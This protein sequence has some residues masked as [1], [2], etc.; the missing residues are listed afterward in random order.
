VL[1]NLFYEPST[2]TS[3]SF[4]TAMMRLGG[5]VLPLTDVS[6]SSVAKGETLSDTV[7]CL[8][9][10]CDVLVLRHPQTGSVALAADAADRIPVL[11]AGDGVGEHPTQSLLDL[12]TITQKLGA[13]DGLTV[14]MLGDLKNGRTVHS[15]AKL[16]AKFTNVTVNYVSPDS[17]RMPAEL[18]ASLAAAGLKQTES[19]S[20]DAAT[21]GATDVLYVTRVQ[22]ERFATPEA[23]QAVANSFVVDART[24]ANAK[25]VLLHWADSVSLSFLQV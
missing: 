1:A 9:S 15:L 7:K 13:V 21:M 24:M 2:R 25:E 19:A 11:N 16:L 10:Y 20:L 3:S 6:N 18:V 22:K 14:T 12:F 5:S 23:Y 17:L 8:Q 4:H